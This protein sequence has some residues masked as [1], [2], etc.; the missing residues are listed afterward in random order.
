[1]YFTINEQ[2]TAFLFSV[3][4][5]CIYAIV[6]DF[7]RIAR[8][9]IPVGIL[10]TAIQDAVYWFII[11][12]ATF[13][14][15]Y[16]TNDGEIRAFIFLGIFIGYLL[17]LFTLSKFFIKGIIW[18]ITFVQKVIGF[19]WRII[20]IPIKFILR[21]VLKFERW[22]KRKIVRYLKNIKKL[23][24]FKIKSIYIRYKPKNIKK[25]NKKLIFNKKN[26]KKDKKTIEKIGENV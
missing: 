16:L 11:T 17:Y 10:G 6:Y 21:P 9:K 8:R 4:L 5:G 19:L 15:L 25:F 13:I 20:C 26:P 2:C 12:C 7:L 1:M 3:L 22:L 14:F 24:I 23:L 18:L